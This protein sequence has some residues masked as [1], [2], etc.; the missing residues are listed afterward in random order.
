MI[1]LQR[2][3][4]PSDM[5]LEAYTRSPIRDSNTLLDLFSHSNTVLDSFCSSNLTSILL[6]SSIISRKTRWTLNLVSS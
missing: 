3:G 6:E 1:I 4:L 2:N 5:T